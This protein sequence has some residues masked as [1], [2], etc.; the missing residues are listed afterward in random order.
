MPEPIHATDTLANERTYLAYIRTALA[1]I[2]FGFVIA[3]FSLFAREFSV[4]VHSGS[5]EPGVSTAF[6]TAMA[7]FGIVVALLGAWRYARTDR[8]LREGRV[9][10]LAGLTG[11]A[12]SLFVVAIGAVVAFALVSYK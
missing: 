6:G 12:I 8:G 2:A 7:G 11:Y 1:F 9:I 4:L 3:R 10:A 5:P